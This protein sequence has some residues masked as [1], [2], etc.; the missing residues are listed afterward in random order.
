M[1]KKSDYFLGTEIYPRN[2]Q[3]IVKKYRSSNQHAND[4]IS[5]MK[6]LKT[7]SSEHLKKKKKYRSKTERD[8]RLLDSI[9]AALSCLVCV[10]PREERLVSGEERGLLSRTAAGDRAYKIA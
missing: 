9:S 1:K 7:T 8:V 2:H 5:L 3:I 4:E 6:G 10:P